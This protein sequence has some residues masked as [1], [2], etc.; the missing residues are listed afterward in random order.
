MFSTMKK[1][2]IDDKAILWQVFSLKG[3]RVCSK[4]PEH[5]RLGSHHFSNTSTVAQVKSSNLRQSISLQSSSGISNLLEEVEQHMF[6]CINLAG[7]PVQSI[8]S[9]PVFSTS[10]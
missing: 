8:Q 6:I 7:N 1:N 5:L 3:S 4:E 9:F 10:A 2:L